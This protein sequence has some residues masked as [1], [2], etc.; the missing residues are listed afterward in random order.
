MSALR[1]PLKLDEEHERDLAERLRLAEVDRVPVVLEI[2]G[3]RYRLVPEAK[4]EIQLAD[5]NDPF[6]N[7][8]PVAVRAALDAAAGMFKGMDV[9]AFPEEILEERIQDTPGHSY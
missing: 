2:A 4:T 7:Y 3:E 8:D 5:E 6:A 1:H 9:D